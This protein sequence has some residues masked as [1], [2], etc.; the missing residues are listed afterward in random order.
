MPSGENK[1]YDSNDCGSI[2]SCD[3]KER[4]GKSKRNAVGHRQEHCGRTPTTNPVK[5]TEALDST[6][7][8]RRVENSASA[9]TMESGSD[10]TR[11]GPWMLV[12]RKPKRPN[13]GKKPITNQPNLE[14]NRFGPLQN[15]KEGPFKY[16]H[17]EPKHKAKM[18]QTQPS[19]S[20]P[21]TVFTATENQP[22]SSCMDRDM[23]LTSDVDTI[24]EVQITTV[25]ALSPSENP[26]VKSNKVDTEMKRN[27]AD[28][29]DHPTSTSTTSSELVNFHNSLTFPNHNQPANEPNSNLTQQHHSHLSPVQSN[30][31]ERPPDTSIRHGSNRT[32]P[33]SHEIQQCEFVHRA[34]DRSNSPS[35]RI[36]VGRTS[37]DEYR[38]KMDM[39]LR[40][41]STP[42][43]TCINE[44]HSGGL[45]ES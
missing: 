40:L 27:K 29:S 26:A 44:V 42:G 15:A 13:Q 8:H 35:R 19:T 36:M 3:E 2:S 23:L 34:R 25:N 37:K 16:K 18:A 17:S 28:A 5:S 20:K 9:E 1:C 39:P 38:A 6:N 14:K 22:D 31:K 11:Y 4:L 41:H 24:P 10:E 21:N 33:P 12:A 7:A 45:Q 30:L 32:D 43:E